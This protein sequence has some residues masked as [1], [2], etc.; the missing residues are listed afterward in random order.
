VGT[1]WA[2]F[3]RQIFFEAMKIGYAAFFRAFDF[4]GKQD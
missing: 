4:A 2:K 1:L 3:A